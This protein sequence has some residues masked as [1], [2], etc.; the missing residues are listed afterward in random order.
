MITLPLVIVVPNELPVWQALLHVVNHASYHC[1][2]LTASDH[3]DFPPTTQ[4]SVLVVTQLVT[5]A[6]SPRIQHL[7][8]PAFLVGDVSYSMPL[9][10]LAS[11]PPPTSNLGAKHG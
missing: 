8:N 1:G 4:V 7:P 3:R 10:P 2:E 9:P 5:G 11:A 6:T